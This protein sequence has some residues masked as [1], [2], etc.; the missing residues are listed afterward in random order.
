M[1]VYLSVDLDY[2][3]ANEND[4]PFCTRFINRLFSLNVPILVVREH[5][6]MLTD[7]N[8]S[9]CSHIEHVDYHSDLVDWPREGKKFT[10]LQYDSRMNLNCGSWLSY[11]M[12]RRRG[13]IRWRYPID[14]C[15]RTPD[16]LG[17]CHTLVNP[18]E[19]DVSGW[20]KTSH[21]SGLSDL[22]WRD[23]SKIGIAIS[24]DYWFDEGETYEN[25]LPRLIGESKLPKKSWYDMCRR[26]TFGKFRRRIR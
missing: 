21:Q 3:G 15:F 16:A 10:D 20:Y 9:G 17:M 7:V 25:V 6:H 2:W 11:V 14:N 18:F 12:W 1:S 22:P 5:H 19:F 26:R 13:S 4:K 24:D 8:N 23:I